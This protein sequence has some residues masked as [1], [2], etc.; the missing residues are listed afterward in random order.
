MT[1]RTRTYA[2]LAAAVVTLGLTT[3]CA[4]KDDAPTGNPMTQKE[5]EKQISGMYEPDDPDAKLTVK[6]EGDLAAEADATQDCTVTTDDDEVG[7]RAQVTDT[8][9]DD[10]GVE[11]MAFL[12]PET[13]ADAIAQ[14]LEIQGYTG[15]ESTCDGN[16]YGEVGREVTCEVTTPDGDTTVEVDV[17]S[18]DGLMINFD[19]KSA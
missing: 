4:A 19:F 12:P 16:L 13:V 14:S 7:V 8:E 11:T 5:L 1:H 15:V 17:T 3:S 18:V 6:C 9:A 2:A 10:L